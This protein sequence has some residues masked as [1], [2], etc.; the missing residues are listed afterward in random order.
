MRTGAI[1]VQ[2]RSIH[3]MMQWE[4]KAT[5]W[6]E[7]LLNKLVYIYHLVSDYSVCFPWPD[8]PP[9]HSVL[10][11]WFKY[12]PLAVGIDWGWYYHPQCRS[13]SESNI[14][15]IINFRVI[16]WTVMNQGCISVQLRCWSC[17]VAMTGDLLEWRFLTDLTFLSSS[18]AM[19]IFHKECSYP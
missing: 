16:D 11:V 2:F 9:H 12:L 15:I 14:Y 13:R 10:R 17:C 18:Y 7:K 6:S 3:L 5:I 4:K 19:H 8:I 1:M